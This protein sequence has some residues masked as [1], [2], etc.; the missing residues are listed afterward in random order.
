MVFLC[1]K[2]L[3]ICKMGMHYPLFPNFE[4]KMWFPTHNFEIIFLK[5][6][7]CWEISGNFRKF[8][9]DPISDVSGN[10]RFPEISGNFLR[11]QIF[12]NFPSGRYLT[13]PTDLTLHRACFRLDTTSRVRQFEDTSC[14]H[15]AGR[16]VPQVLSRFDAPSCVLPVDATS[17]A[18]LVLRS[19]VGASGWTLP[20][21][22][23]RLDAPGRYLTRPAGQT[24]WT[25]PHAPGRFDAPSC[26]LP[27][28][29]LPHASRRFDD[30]SCD[31]PAGRYLT[32]K[33]VWRYLVCSSGWTIRTARARR[34]DAPSCVL[35][36]GRYLVCPA[37]LTI[38]RACFRLDTT[39]R[40]RPVR[41]STMR[42][43]RLDATSR[44][45]AV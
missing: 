19:I 39:S 1:L 35:P 8:P 2:R 4:L 9:R 33:P 45:Q 22:P 6:Y 7:Y 17:R 41:R 25:L 15:S 13:R 3:F 23:G 26:V 40:A 34:F 11:H 36:T 5:I 27:A 24:L 37:G 21:A 31:H 29:T 43:S 28:W 38:H 42:A 14:V 44:A 30:T 10:F 32:R 12:G 18:R 16:Y 20:H